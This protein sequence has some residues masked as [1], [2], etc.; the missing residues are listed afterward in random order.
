MDLLLLEYNSDGIS[1]IRFINSEEISGWKYQANG[2]L[3]INS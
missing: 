1:E 2:L 3:K